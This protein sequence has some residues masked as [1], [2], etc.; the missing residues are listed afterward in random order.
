MLSKKLSLTLIGTSILLCSSLVAAPHLKQVKAFLN[1]NITYTLDGTAILEGTNTLNYND[2]NYISVAELAKAL[3]LEVSYKDNVVSFVTSHKEDTTMQPSDANSITIAKATIKELYLDT[4]Q[5]TILPEGMPNEPRYYIVLNI[6]S[7][8]VIKDDVNKAIYKLNDL[9][10]GMTISVT[11]SLAM[12]RSLPPQT[13]AFTITILGDHE[14]VVANP[15]SITLENRVV[16]EVNHKENYF[17]VTPQ[18]ADANDI[19]NQ[20]IIRYDQNTKLSFDN[21]PKQPNINSLKVG[22]LVTL[23][24]SP[25][26]TLSIPPQTFALEIKVH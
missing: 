24:I 13:E 2:K 7:N 6:S 12:T 25:A 21:S 22:A 5:L 16:V 11:H 20:T 4:N 14:D 17:V 8:T 10:E 19:N 18:G 3:G 9:S 15:E 1:P 23:H 26:M